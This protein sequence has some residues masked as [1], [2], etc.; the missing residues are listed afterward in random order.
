M[1]L[2]KYTGVHPYVAER[3]RYILSFADEAGANYWITS[4]D[5]SHMEQACLYDTEDRWPVARPGCSQ[6]EYGLAMDVVMQDGRWQDWFLQSA[7]NVGLVTVAGDRVHVQAIPG[8]QFIEI[9][10]PFGVC[11]DRSLMPGGAGYF[12]GFCG[13]HTTVQ[14]VRLHPRD[15]LPVWCT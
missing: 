8:G 7:R 2:S 11:P 1:P 12:P 3:V 15:R 14:G 4:G 13:C 10:A 6:H 5:R 9:L